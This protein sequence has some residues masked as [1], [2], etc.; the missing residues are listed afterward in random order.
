VIC[1][2]E[3]EQLVVLVVRVGHRRDVYDR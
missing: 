3:D 2:I 1:R